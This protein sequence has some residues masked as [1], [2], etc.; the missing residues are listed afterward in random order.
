[1]IETQENF[2]AK[3][4]RLITENPGV[5][6]LSFVGPGIDDSALIQFD[7]CELMRMVKYN[8]AIH[9]AYPRAETADLCAAIESEFERENA[10]LRL[11]ESALAERVQHVMDTLHWEPCILL[12]DSKKLFDIVSASFGFRDNA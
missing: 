9:F 11:S 5:P 4:A 10:D 12:H 3:L 7:T 1:M 8:G 2:N 6:I